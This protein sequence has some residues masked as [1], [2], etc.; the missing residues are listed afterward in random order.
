MSRAVREGGS[1]CDAWRNMVPASNEA[2]VGRAS[3]MAPN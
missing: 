1:F 3:H 2:R